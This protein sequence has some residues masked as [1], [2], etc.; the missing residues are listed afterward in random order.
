[1]RGAKKGG[2]DGRENPKKKKTDYHMFFD[3]I[4]MTSIGGRPQV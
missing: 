4:D 1:M 3:G 2:K